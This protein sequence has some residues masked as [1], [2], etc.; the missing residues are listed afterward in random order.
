MP[1]S[2]ASR[3][4]VVALAAVLATIVPSDDLRS[5]GLPEGEF[6]AQ[7]AAE[8]ELGWGGTADF[9][10]TVTSG[11]S[12]TTT[13]SLGARVT[14]D[15][16]RQRLSFSGSYLRTTE[17]GEEVAHR[18]ELTSLYRYFPNARF[19]LTA[20]SSGSFNEPAGLDLRLSPGAGVGYLVAQGESFQ[21]SAEAGANWIRDA[22]VDGTRTTAF[23]YAMA[24][25]FSLQLS[26]TT[27]FEQELRYN[28][29]AGDLSDYLIHGEATL[30][31]Q[32]TDALGLRL[33]LIDDFDATPFQ[34]GPDQPPASKNDLT[35]IAGVSVQW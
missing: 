7:E 14:R 13:L 6:S 17:E 3:P 2:C 33:T 30:T 5:Q 8:E 25:S 11:N 20:R 9:G 16:A 34:G 22:F 1:S 18:G 10:L 31:T 27:T 4:I 35:F 21:L 19:Y 29:R 23:Y 24:E 28:P 26:E 32:I 15:F 12:E